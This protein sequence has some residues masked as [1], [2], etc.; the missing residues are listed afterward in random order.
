MT[1]NHYTMWLINFMRAALI[2]TAFFTTSCSNPAGNNSDGKTDAGVHKQSKSKLPT[3][4]CE[5]AYLSFS[6][7]NKGPELLHSAMMSYDEFQDI[8]KRYP[9]IKR[10]YEMGEDFSQGRKPYDEVMYGGRF[11][12]DHPLI[13]IYGYELKEKEKSMM[14]KQAI[15]ESVQRYYDEMRKQLRG[16][17][18][19]WDDL[20]LNDCYTKNYHFEGENLYEFAGDKFE[21]P[22][23]KRVN[24]QIVM[25]GG[26][27][28]FQDAMVETKNGWRFLPPVDLIWD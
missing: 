8:K 28:S 2:C 10:M 17:G 20:R 23:M 14:L 24:M 4:P 3:D 22:R 16:A 18:I 1:I 5:L 13:L 15:P 19:I 7:L 12:F 26:I 27:E 25:Q 21:I 9:D 6:T 11:F